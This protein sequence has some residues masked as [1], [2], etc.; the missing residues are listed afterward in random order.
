MLNKRSILEE[1]GV[2]DDIIY[3]FIKKGLIVPE[4]IASVPNPLRSPSEEWFYSIADCYTPPLDNIER[5]IFN[6][7]PH[8]LVLKIYDAVNLLYDLS[9]ILH[10]AIDNIEKISE[11]NDKVVALLSIMWIFHGCL[12]NNYLKYDRHLEYLNYDVSPVGHWWKKLRAILTEVVKRDSDY[13]NTHVDS[14]ILK[15]LKAPRRPVITNEYQI[16]CAKLYNEVKKYY[17]ENSSSEKI[18]RLI[19]ET[20]YQLYAKI[21]E[22][23]T[24]FYTEP[25]KFMNDILLTRGKISRTKVLY[26]SKEDTIN[27]IREIKELLPEEKV[28]EFERTI[29][30]IEDF[31]FIQELEGLIA[32]GKR[33]NCD[34]G[35]FEVLLRCFDILKQYLSNYPNLINEE[36]RKHVIH[37]LNNARTIPDKFVVDRDIVVNLNK[38]FINGVVN[39]VRDEIG[40][41]KK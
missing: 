25:K 1:L 36:Y 30:T 12:D 31:V 33:K 16:V 15:L 10:K 39:K 32:Y 37:M 20:N 8:L 29:E 3:F 24:L 6:E 38:Y 7:N 28:Y 13:S 40:R 19:K 26:K 2:S 5:E 18:L 23:A 17:K 35:I 21:K 41:W 11:D 9:I 4:K 34:Y 22:Y 27:F 14:Y